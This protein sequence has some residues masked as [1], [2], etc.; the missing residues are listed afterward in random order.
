MDSA[1]DC[2][3]LSPNTSSVRVEIT[4]EELRTALKE[5][6]EAKSDRQPS[7]DPDTTV[8]SR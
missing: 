5:L 4:A 8:H 6:E 3:E 1:F 7:H 2:T